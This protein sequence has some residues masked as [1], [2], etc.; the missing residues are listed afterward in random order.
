[1]SEAVHI[2]ALATIA[3][4][5]A[6][7]LEKVVQ[8]CAKHSLQEKACKR[9]E[10]SRDAENEGRF[11]VSEIWASQEGFEAHLATDHFGALADFAK[12]HGAELE[13]IRQ[14]PLHPAS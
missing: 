11:T 9:Y 13:V 1:M 10:I 14:V 3:K 2:L 4:G 5:K 12:E 6:A 8:E 7:E